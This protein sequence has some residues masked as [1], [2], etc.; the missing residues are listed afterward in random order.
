VTPRVVVVGAGPAGLAAA[1]AAADDGCEV[2]VLD[3][4]RAPGGQYLRQPLVAGVEP[5]H[6]RSRRSRELLAR[7][8]SHDRVR[9]RT[10]AQVWHATPPAAGGDGG[11]RL[12]LIRGERTYE[13]SAGTVV[14]ATGATER[15]LPFPGWDLPGVVTAGA[16]QALLKGE[17]VLVGRRV[18][19]AGSGPFLLAVAA[20]LARAGAAVV[21]VDEA[22]AAAR[23]LRHAAVVAANPRKVRE[24][25][26]YAAALRRHGVRVRTGA[27]VTAV[28]QDG[29]SL[30]ASVSAVDAQWRSRP[31]R[32]SASRRDAGRSWEHRVDAVCVGHGFTPSIELALGLG[33]ATARDSASGSLVAVVDDLQRSSVP[34]VLVAGEAT[35]V[36]GADLAM[37]EGEIAGHVAASSDGTARLLERTAEAR[38][39]RAR[40]LAL[41]RAVHAVHRIPAG[42]TSWLREDTTVCRCEDVP[43]A[44]LREGVVDLGADD[45]RS[46]KLVTRVG[47]GLCQARMCGENVC[48]L[49][50]SFTGLAQD[51]TAFASRPLAVPVPLCALAVAAPEEGDPL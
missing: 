32:A 31:A 46:A 48:A 16:A 10:G 1:V 15:V 4:G 47:M 44:A 14:L 42:W 7:A 50:E 41:S 20:D 3:A 8:R 2:T 25:A 28:R 36:G 5:S 13:M 19:V 34:G 40:E 30:V 6:S 26:T 38:R 22:V 49:L 11:V 35:G 29:D 21:E 9:L 37:T 24:G 45:V 12:H 23:W 18:L 43:L 17:G 33:C 39:R 27:A 51:A